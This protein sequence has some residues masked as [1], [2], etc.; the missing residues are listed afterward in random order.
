MFS[1]IKIL[2]DVFLQDLII[3]QF[4]ILPDEKSI[5]LENDQLT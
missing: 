5:Y 3:K 4:K 1:Q 2:Q